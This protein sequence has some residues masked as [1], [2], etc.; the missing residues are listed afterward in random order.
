MKTKNL[1]NLLQRVAPSVGNGAFLPI[2][3][4]VLFECKEG[5]LKL[6]TTD[7]LN[8]ITVTGET[9]FKDCSLCIPFKE[10]TDILRN[11]TSEDVSITIEGETVTIK[12]GKGRFKIVGF[13]SKDFQL[14]PKVEGESFIIEGLQFGLKQAAFATSSEAY[15]G[16]HGVLID[17]KEGYVN[18]VGTDT[19]KLIMYTTDSDKEF[20][21]ILNK[22]SSSIVSGLEGD[23]SVTIEPRCVLFESEG[24]MMQSTLIDAIYPNYEAIVPK[25]SNFAIEVD[26]SEFLSVLKRSSIMSSVV[27][28]SLCPGIM[29]ISGVNSDNQ[30][31]SNESIV[32]NYNGEIF[33]IGFNPKIWI[34]VLS[35]IVSDTVSLGFTEKKR[36]CVITTD[37]GA[38]SLIMPLHVA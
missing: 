22:K 2:L 35:Q 31:E 11:L 1:L 27:K 26:K 21:V 32:I 10:L 5:A 33:E 14:P 7:Q 37:Y 12:A 6:T 24:F 25:E 13:S 15:N 36:P 3:S 34:D 28:F 18:F 8:T 23:V 4:T 20:K 17:A 29:T 30:S 19:A 9:D 38:K 16:L